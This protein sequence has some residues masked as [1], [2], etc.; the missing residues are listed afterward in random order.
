MI[1]RMPGYCTPNPERFWTKV[2]ITDKDKCW[3]WTASI[4]NKGYGIIGWEEKNRSA[5]RLAWELTFGK[6]P[7]GLC[8]CHHCDNPACCNPSHLFLGTH[9]DNMNDRDQ[10]GRDANHA[11]ENNGNHK[12]TLKQAEEI[13]ERYALGKERQVDIAKSFGVSQELISRI[14]LHQSWG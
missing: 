3:N 7:E 9:K 6:I 8:V 1:A 11:G 12:I 14:I 13:R 4:T 2:N 10:K 5:H